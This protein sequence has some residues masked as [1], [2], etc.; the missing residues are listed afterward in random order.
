MSWSLRRD[1]FTNYIHPTLHSRSV[2]GAIWLVIT[3]HVLMRLLSALSRSVPFVHIHGLVVGCVCGCQWADI[4]T[5]LMM[6]KHV[7]HKLGTYKFILIELLR[8]G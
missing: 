7:L 1:L 6:A 8:A 2:L 4:V 3:Y 5:V